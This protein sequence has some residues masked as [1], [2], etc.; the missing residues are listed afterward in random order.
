M[1][2]RMRHRKGVAWGAAATLSMALLAAIGPGSTGVRTVQ[3]VDGPTGDRGRTTSTLPASQGPPGGNGDAS[4]APS[5]AA[6]AA[7]SG[8][9]VAGPKS[10]TT[11]SH[12]SQPDTTGPRPIAE[13]PQSGGVLRGPLQVDGNRILDADGQAVVLRGV[14]RVGLEQLGTVPPM[15]DGEVAHARAWGSNVVRLPLGEAYVNADCPNQYVPAYYDQLDAAVQSITSRGMVALLDL[16]TGTRVPCGES[17][18][19]RMADK[20]MSV[21]FWRAVASRYKANPLV[22]FDLYNEPHDITNDQWRNGGDLTDLGPRGGWV[23]W[24]AAGMQD[25]Y[26]AVR[27]TGATNLVTIS[28][29][30]FGGNPSA[31]LDG[32][33]V[34]GTNIVYGAHIYTCSA[35]NQWCT[36][37]PS[38][39]T[40]E[41]NPLWTSVAARYPVM[42]TE[43]GWP[44][45]S[46]GVYNDSVI[47]AAQAQNPPWG[48]IA[49]A[50]NGRTTDVFGLVADLTTYEPT[51]SGAPVKAAL[52]S[53]P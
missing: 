37:T 5:D 12:G 32:D 42:V 45:Q 43:F 13:P 48:W 3:T 11:G 41:I 28:A 6:A 47:R 27:S 7:A 23:N 39:Q 52:S 1:V 38:N 8:A 31:I 24:K 18:R 22:A 50:W 17:Q 19:W 49:Y 20:P 26:D 15:T 29:N 30:G 10:T 34:T 14:N 2:Q 4:S 25:L 53:P 40:A 33:A 35:P 21:N 9:T 51:P 46:S 36:S 16:H 44:D